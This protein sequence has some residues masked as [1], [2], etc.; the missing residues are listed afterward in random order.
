MAVPWYQYQTEETLKTLETDAAAGLSAAEAVLRQERY[1][2]NELVERGGRTRWQIL[3]DQIKGVLTLILVGA[4]LISIFLEEYVDSVVIL[5]I[6]VLNA[7]LGFVQE[8][9]AEQSMAALKR[10]AVP[11]VRVRREAHV[12]EVSALDLVPGDIVLLVTGN[13]VPSDGRVLLS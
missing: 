7:I 11:T 12:Q 3:L 6:V 4:A 13:V 1:G 9:R 2:F 10:M 8:Y 5:A